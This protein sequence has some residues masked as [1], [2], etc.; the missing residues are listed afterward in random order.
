MAEVVSYEGQYGLRAVLQAL[1]GVRLLLDSERL[2]PEQAAGYLGCINLHLA[3]MLGVRG[4]MMEQLEKCGGL[5]CPHCKGFV[6]TINNLSATCPHCG[7]RLFPVT[8]H[9]PDASQ[10]EGREPGE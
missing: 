4:E 1:E 6:G 8:G 9:L 10:E 7:T 5:I 3:K 2:G